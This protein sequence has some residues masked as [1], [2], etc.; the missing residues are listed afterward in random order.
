MRWGVGKLHGQGVGMR[1]FL[2]VMIVGLVSG[3]V[4][5]A[6]PVVYREGDIIVALAQVEPGKTEWS[7]EEMEEGR[8]LGILA[9]ILV[10][11][12][13]PL[14]EYQALIVAKMAEYRSMQ[15]ALPVL[16]TRITTAKD[17]NTPVLAVVTLRVMASVDALIAKN[18]N[19]P[20]AQP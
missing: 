14:A 1:L 4:G 17:V 20:A 11:P 12:T 5:A 15:M 3:V 13:F 19:E 9:P 2:R 10:L 18:I 6:E 7:A 16:L 8:R